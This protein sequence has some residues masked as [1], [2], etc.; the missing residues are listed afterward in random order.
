[1]TSLT[2]KEIERKRLLISKF[3]EDNIDRTEIQELI[4]ILEKEKHIAEEEDGEGESGMLV[5][6]ISSLISHL[7]EYV[8]S[9]SGIQEEQL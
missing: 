8:K 5:F 2:S 7:S 3:K 1:M 6:A 9:Q 4:A